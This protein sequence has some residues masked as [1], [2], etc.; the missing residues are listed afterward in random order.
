MSKETKDKNL[1][2]S[3]LIELINHFKEIKDKIIKIVTGG[4]LKIYY[5]P[6]EN[7]IQNFYVEYLSLSPNLTY[8][9]ECFDIKDIAIYI[10]SSYVYYKDSSLFNGKYDVENKIIEIKQFLEKYVNQLKY[11]GNYSSYQRTDK[12]KNNKDIIFKYSEKLNN[13]KYINVN[14]KLNKKYL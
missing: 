6:F 1:E 7:Y 14:I 10:S 12:G 5:N 9:D 3:F 4:K 2:K 13:G 11:D 8:N